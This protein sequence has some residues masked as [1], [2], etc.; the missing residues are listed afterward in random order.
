M[1]IDN[2]NVRL[3]TINEDDSVE[4]LFKNQTFMVIPKDR[5]EIKGENK[6]SRIIEAHVSFEGDVE[7]AMHKVGWNNS[8]IENAYNELQEALREIQKD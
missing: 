7:H 5:V 1:Y 6:K 8:R 4:I 2:S 3:V